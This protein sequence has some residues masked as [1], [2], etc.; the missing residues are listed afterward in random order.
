MCEDRPEQVDTSN[1]FVDLSLFKKH[2]A[3]HSLEEGRTLREHQKHGKHRNRRRQEEAARSL[4]D[5][6][7]REGEGMVHIFLLVRRV[8]LFVCTICV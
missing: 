7:R 5:G 4:I 3:M 1:Y 2:V 8:L 6:E